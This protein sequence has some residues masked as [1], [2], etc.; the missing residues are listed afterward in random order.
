MKKVLLIISILFLLTGCDVKLSDDYKVD[1]T[2]SNSCNQ[3]LNK[4]YSN[5]KQ[6]VYLGC[7]DSITLKD[8][9][10]D[11]ELNKY[12]KQKDVNLNTTIDNIINK[13]LGNVSLGN[14][15]LITYR[16]GGSMIYSKND[17]IIITCD[18]PKDNNDVYILTNDFKINN[19]SLSGYCGYN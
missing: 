14:G 16:D 8:D 4:Y 5:D 1:I 11:I 3:K 6:S 7:I 18:T 17:Y 9:K 13:V 19:N 12:L 2:N 10:Q 15:S